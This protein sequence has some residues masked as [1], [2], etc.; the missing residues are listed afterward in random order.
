VRVAL[1]GCLAVC[2]CSFTQGST[3][4]D[5]E[6]DSFNPPVDIVDGSSERTR[7]RLTG[8][9]SFESSGFPI[10]D[11]AG[12]F[13][14][15]E[16][17]IISGTAI[18]GGGTMQISTA[19]VIGSD[20]APR[21]NQQ[22]PPQG[23][24]ALE[25]W[26]AAAETEQG[27]SRP[28]LIAGLSASLNSRNIA[29]MQSNNRWLA[30]VRTSGDANGMPDLLS[31]S[32]VTTAMTHILVTADANARA[33]YVNGVKEAESTPGGPQGWDSAYRFVL[34]NEPQGGSPW[35]GAY[36]L[37]ALYERGLSAA[38]IEGNYRAGPSAEP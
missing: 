30:R 18:S 4:L 35:L 9:W 1:H 26:V 32:E 8:A 29:L 20:P 6:L 11:V 25:V 2:A 22:I 17:D 28:S 37:V 36:S 27:V 3:P 12:R 34:A 38:E 24:V 16:L 10:P 33:L 21:F 23:G 31:T 5:A 7:L 14:P 19:T 15:V 13:P